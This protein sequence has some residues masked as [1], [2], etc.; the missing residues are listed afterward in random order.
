[1]KRKTS[2]GLNWIGAMISRLRKSGGASMAELESQNSLYV[3]FFVSI[4]HRFTSFSLGSLNTSSYKVHTLVESTY[5]FMAK[6][7]ER[8]I[9][10]L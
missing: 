4:F 6:V 7:T 3:S 2:N 9:V 5:I 1:M 8:N 10:A